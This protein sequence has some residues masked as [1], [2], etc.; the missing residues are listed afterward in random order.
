MLFTTAPTAQQ[1]RD[2]KFNYEKRSDQ[3]VFETIEDVLKYID[4]AREFLNGLE[5]NHRTGGEDVPLFDGLVLRTYRVPHKPPR[6][7][8][9][10]IERKRFLV[11]G[12]HFD[13]ELVGTGALVAKASEAGH[14]VCVLIFC[15][16]SSGRADHGLNSENGWLVRLYETMQGA[17]IVGIDE[18]HVILGANGIGLPEWYWGSDHAWCRR[19]ATELGRR[20]NIDY[21]LSHHD[22]PNVDNHPDHSAVGRIGVAWVNQAQWT[23]HHTSMIPDYRIPSGE[24]IRHPVLLKYV[25]WPGKVNPGLNDVLE[26]DLPT[27]ILVASAIG[28]HLTQTVPVYNGPWGID[29]TYAL[30]WLGPRLGLRFGLDVNRPDMTFFEGYESPSGVKVASVL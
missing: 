5:V 18:I 20:Y 24:E 12:A 10:E 6:A 16:G 7:K 30:M 29:N 19:L 28:K 25:V 26:F 9:P 11:L 2:A 27:A 17:L 4:Q 1:L 23:D 21:L 22:D 14:E 3:R 15:G 13:D 8:L